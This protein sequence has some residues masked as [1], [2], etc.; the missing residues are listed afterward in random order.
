MV[1][2]QV[3]SINVVHIS[4]AAVRVVHPGDARRRPVKNAFSIPFRSPATPAIFPEM[5][6]PPKK[7]GKP[8]RQDGAQP[9]AKAQ[10]PAVRPLGPALADLLNPALNKGEAGIGSG[11][12]LQPPPNNSRARRSDYASEHTARASTAGKDAP[13]FGEKPQANY[14]TAATVPTLDPELARQLGL[15][16]GDDDDTLRPPRTKMEGLGVAA[17]A[18]S[19]ENL[20]R[21]GISR[22]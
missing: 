15:D 8:V 12:G 3:A 13:F 22:R 7:T 14:G 9:S 1:G 10:R 11:T 4:Q 18:Q 6:K 19:L 17:T 2:P 20:L 16:V 5:S 21:D